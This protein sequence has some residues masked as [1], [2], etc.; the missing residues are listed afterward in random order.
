MD[1]DGVGAEALLLRREGGR[2]EADDVARGEGLRLGKALDVE[3]HRIGAGLRE[4]QLRRH[5]GAVEAGHRLHGEGPLGA[6]GGDD[7]R[8]DLEGA[9]FAQ[10]AR[11]GNDNLRFVTRVEDVRRG[12]ET[13]ADGIGTLF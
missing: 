13:E 2:L 3:L 10:P 1:V 4:G 5:G 12:R 11:G 7:L 8:R 6:V 9:R